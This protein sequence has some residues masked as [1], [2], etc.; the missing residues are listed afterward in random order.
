MTSDG[1]RYS[2]IDPDQEISAAPCADRRHRAAEPEPVPRRHVALGDREEAREPRLGGEQVVA[3]GVER[4]RRRRDSRSTAACARD[5]AGSRIP[6]RAPSSRAVASSAAGAPH[7]RR[8]RVGDRPIVA[9]MARRSMRRSAVDPEQ[10]VRAG[11][12]AALARERARHVGQRLRP[13]P[14]DRRACRDRSVAVRPTHAG[15]ERRRARRRA[16]ASV[17]GL[18]APV[19]AQR[20]AAPRGRGRARRRCRP[21]ALRRGGRRRAIP[22]QALASA[23]RWP[24]RLPLSTDET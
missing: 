11:V 1:I 4:C 5:R 6:S 22:R 16:G 7:E 18:R 17:H 19:V 21:T 9:P 20:V 8:R 3:T 12:V 24:A 10:H 15:R 13:A 14:R 2:N 23:I